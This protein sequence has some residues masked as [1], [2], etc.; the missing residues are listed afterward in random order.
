LHRKAHGQEGTARDYLLYTYTSIASYLILVG[1]LVDY[2]SPSRPSPLVRFVTPEIHEESHH[3]TGVFQAAYGLLRE[4]KLFEHEVT[5]VRET[6]DWFSENLE[7]PARFTKSKP[8]Y[9]RKKQRAISWFRSSATKHLSKL[10]EL[11]T[12]L[13]NHQIPVR[14]IKT[15]R[16]GYIVYEDEIQVV[17]EPFRDT[18]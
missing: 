6:L 9:Y 11:V 14:I 3:A 7:K 8:P 15:T 17:S 13:E 2:M 18:K 1:Q 16:P 4:G 5:Q 12:V 10:R